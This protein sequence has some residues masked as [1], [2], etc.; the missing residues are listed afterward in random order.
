MPENCPVCR[1]VRELLAK[2]LEMP[3]ESD[4][5][6]LAAAAARLLAEREELFRHVNVIHGHFGRSPMTKIHQ[7]SLNVAERMIKH[8]ASICELEPYEPE[9]CDE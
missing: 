1:H 8:M 4:P 2:P 5:R 7:A 6:A 9:E 3:E